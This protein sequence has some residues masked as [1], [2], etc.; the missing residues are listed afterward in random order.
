MRHQST[1]TSVSWIPSEAM[2]MSLMKV[3]VLLGIAHY[4]PPPPDRLA[5]LETM[6]QASEF[7]FA[8]RLGA[9]IEV[10]GDEIVDAGYDG[11]GLISKTVADLKVGSFSFQPVAYPEIRKEPER[12]GGWVRFV[13][14]TGGRTGSPMPRKISRPPYVLITAPT[15]WTTL[16]LTIHSDG[17]AE[18]EVV[19]ASPFPRHWFYDDAGEL[20]QKSG[21][22]DYREWADNMSDDN[23]PWG[24]REHE[25][26]IADAE[27]ELER[28]MSAAIMQ[29]G[30]RPAIRRL[31]EE[32]VLLRQGDEGDEMF[33]ILD[34]IV[35]IDVD[36][37]PVAEAGP[38]AILGERAILEGGKRTSTVTAR[39]SIRV[40]VASADQVD[41]E[42]LTALA[43]THHREDHVEADTPG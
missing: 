6:H 26:L 32:E 37:E 25:L 24:D 15:V 4:D 42:A 11:G 40:A 39:T 36:G 13:Q 30:A 19:G 31:E 18:H 9:W 23:S 14:T 10:E 43:R 16:A 7:R 21:L 3:P 8:N 35:A 1:F 29:G 28:T 20:V 41:L 33:L 22:A 12:D 2:P 38:G 5:D 17:R 27:T 34:G